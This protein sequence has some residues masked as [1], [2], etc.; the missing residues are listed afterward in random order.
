MVYPE[1]V[2]L[3]APPLDNEIHVHANSKYQTADDGRS[4]AWH[5]VIDVHMAEKINKSIENTS[6]SFDG[7]SACITK[8]IQ[9]DNLAI[10]DIH[11]KAPDRKHNIK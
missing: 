10:P 5:Y 9:F 7:T 4:G 11:P 1:Y 2:L 8:Q 3:I 6:L